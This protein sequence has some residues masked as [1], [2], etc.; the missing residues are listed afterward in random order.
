MP[1]TIE[2]EMTFTKS[3]AIVFDC[4]SEGIGVIEH[5][6][7]VKSMSANE[8]L[9][10]HSITFNGKSIC[11]NFLEATAII[12]VNRK[13]EMNSLTQMKAVLMYKQLNRNLYHRILNG[14]FGKKYLS[15]KAKNILFDFKKKVEKWA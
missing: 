8:K 6:G 14:L 3:R 1:T 15:A 12:S 7:Y 9:F 13:K 4:L 11:S 5:L 10:I 2:I